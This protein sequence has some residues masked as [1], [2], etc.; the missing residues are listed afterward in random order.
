LIDTAIQLGIAKYNAA[1]QLVTLDEEYPRAELIAQ[2]EV[3]R[4]LF[5]A[6]YKK[7]MAAALKVPVLYRED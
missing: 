4:E 1:K 7:V 3:N 6:L 5:R 2:L